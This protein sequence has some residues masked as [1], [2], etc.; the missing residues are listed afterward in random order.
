MILSSTY[1]SAPPKSVPPEPVVRIAVR[2]DGVALLA[3]D[4]RAAGHGSIL[5]ALA[6]QLTAA[7]ELVSQNPAVSAVVVQHG[8]ASSLAGANIDFVRSLRFAI[9]AEELARE[10]GRRFAGLADVRPT[11]DPDAAG[12]RNAARKPDSRAVFA[13]GR[14]KRKPVVAYVHGPALGPGFELALA[15]TAMVASDDPTTTFG[16]PEVKLGVTPVAN[17]LLRI[18]E[19]A[20]LRVALDLGLNGRELLAEEALSLGLVDEVVPEAHGLASAVALALRLASLDS[21]AEVER[22]LATGRLRSTRIERIDRALF[23]RNPIG[24]HVVFRRARTAVL[25]TTRGRHPAANAIVELLACLGAKGASAAANLAPRLFGDLAVSDETR[26]LIDLHSARAALDTETGLE[27][28]ERAAPSAVERIGIIGAGVTGSGLAA[29]SAKAGL[30]VRMRDTDDDS[31]G[32]GLRYVDELLGSGRRG[33]RERAG[34]RSRVEGAT[35]YAGF[36]AADLVFEA[37]YEDLTLKRSVL[38]DVAELTSD[39][40]VVASTTSAIPIARIAEAAR[41][42]ELVVGMH[43]FAPV[44][45]T[46]L[47]EVVR[48]SIVD[49]RA[50]A[51][52]VLLGKRQG[53]AV[54]VVRDG[55][56]F[57]ATRILVAYLEEA[58]R[59]LAEGR[60]IERIDSALLD[61]GFSAAPFRHMDETGIDLWVHAAELVGAAFGERL[62]PPAMF[63][64]LRAD[65]RRGKKNARG[66]YLHGT[67]ASRR[68]AVDSTVYGALGIARPLRTASFDADDAAL[69]CALAMVNEAL[70]C[71]GEGVVRSARDGDIGAVLGCGFPAFRGGPFRHVD[72]VGSTEILRQL[73]SLEQRFG[74]RFAPAPLLVETARGGRRFYD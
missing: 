30:A 15:C 11:S 60:S 32:H 44:H 69:R 8:S 7:L 67:L 25:E 17:G 36:D 29:M 18:A 16:L 54:I 33:A 70:H 71:R 13:R 50:I 58:A 21:D 61:W 35:D 74:P 20:G 46:P 4:G 51:T 55:P 41:R 5:L 66:F 40:C 28:A 62:A 38:R 23:E 2:P 9:D 27:P 52:A 56:G 31:V 1:L 34:V 37:V 19:R 47:L 53:K 72:V 45:A 39:S 42:P 65:G 14:A 12:A 3:I 59:I 73:R 49:P 43:Y 48:T 6:G 22:A 57:Y 24:R 64:S 68:V 10:L 26:R 63:E